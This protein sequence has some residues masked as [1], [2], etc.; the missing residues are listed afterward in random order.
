[1]DSFFVLH[2]AQGKKGRISKGNDAGSPSQG[3]AT[4]QGNVLE[5][6]KGYDNEKWH[7]HFLPAQGHYCSPKN[8]RA[9]DAVGI[10][11][12]ENLPAPLRFTIRNFGKRRGKM[13]PMLFCHTQRSMG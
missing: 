6:K 1:M 7:G 5:H 8:M 3:Q 11:L 12:G 13:E 4:G 2:E 9:G 10:S